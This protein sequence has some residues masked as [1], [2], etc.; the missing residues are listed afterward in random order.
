MVL[1]LAM[2]TTTPAPKLS[3]DGPRFLDE[4]RRVS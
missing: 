2:K 3:A 4:T 1:V